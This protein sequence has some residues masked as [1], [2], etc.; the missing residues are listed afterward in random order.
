[1]KSEKGKAQLG[2]LEIRNIY[3]TSDGTCSF[4]EIKETCRRSLAAAMELL[5]RDI[6]NVKMS[7]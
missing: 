6:K 7:S 1:M 2:K 3:A 4:E 5:I